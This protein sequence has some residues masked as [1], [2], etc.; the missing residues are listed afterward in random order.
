MCFCTDVLVDHSQ[1]RNFITIMPLI[2]CIYI[3]NNYF[4]LSVYYWYHQCTR[5]DIYNIYIYIILCIYQCCKWNRIVITFLINN[6]PR[7]Y[8]T[9]SFKNRI[10]TRIIIETCSKMKEDVGIVITNNYN[11]AVNFEYCL[12]DTIPEE[13]INTVNE[14]E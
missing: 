4:L 7:N 2:H 10:E 13:N 8:Y 14:T 5:Y 9:E 6:L 11:I 3:Y 1:I 12:L